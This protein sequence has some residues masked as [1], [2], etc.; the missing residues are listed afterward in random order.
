M[1]DGGSRA[2]PARDGRNRSVNWGQ[3]MKKRGKI[4]RDT[5]T[6]PGLI[7]ADGQQYTFSLEGLWKSTEAP[8]VDM[9]VDVEFGDQGG[10]TGITVVPDSQLA[11]EQAEFAMNAARDRGAALAAGAVAKFGVPSLVAAAALIIGWWMLPAVS[12]SMF[13]ASRSVT[14]WS[15][16]GY[17]NSGVL[18]GGFGGGSP[19]SGIY[20]LLA[21]VALVGPFLTYFWKDRRALLGGLLPLIFMIFA[22]FMALHGLDKI[23]G[24]TPGGNA[25]MSEATKAVSVGSGVY[26]SAIA[27]LYFAGTSTMKFLAAMARRG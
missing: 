12:V 1:G 19:S 16:L 14:F 27:S 9:V 13:G 4:L 6:G 22:F 21:I 8:K 18:S 10:I 3:A 15:A 24:G 5:S 2:V 23:A 17:I 11:R 20:G 25:M 26:L 7:V